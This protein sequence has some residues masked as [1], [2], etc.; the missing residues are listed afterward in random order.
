MLRTQ[1]QT[2]VKPCRNSGLSLIE[3]MIA[4]AVGLMI[5]VIAMNYLISNI[6]TRNVNAAYSTLKDNGAVALYFLAHYGRS[7]GLETVP[8]YGDTSAT[9]G[10]C[11]ATDPKCSFESTTV[12][13]RV[14][15]RKLYPDETIACNGEIVPAGEELVEIFS[16]TSTADYD[17][18]VCQ[19]YSLTSAAWLGSDNARVLQTGI[20]DFQVQYYIKDTPTPV[21]ADAVTNWNSVQ[22]I[23]VA[24]L[25]NSELPAHVQVIDQRFVLLDRDKTTFTDRFARQIFQTSIAFNN[26]ALNEEEP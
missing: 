15:I 23:E 26:A 18:L 4:M 10:L 5:T 7:A 2:K 12:S 11:N 21:A 19:S 22:G 6:K 3:L 25:A 1:T 8:I 9:G 24:V 20:E 16:L 17:A 13:D 14:A